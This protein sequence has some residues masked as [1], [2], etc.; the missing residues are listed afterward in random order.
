[1]P[2]AGAGRHAHALCRQPRRH[3]GAQ[4]LDEGPPRNGAIRADA[5]LGTEGE[6]LDVLPL[7]MVVVSTFA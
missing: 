5:G 4:R 2:H 6:S 7:G 1:M 3:D